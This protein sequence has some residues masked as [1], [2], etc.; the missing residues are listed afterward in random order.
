MLLCDGP[1]TR[2]PHPSHVMI[3]CC[4]LSVGVGSCSQGTAPNSNNVRQPLANRAYHNIT[5]KKTVVQ[6]V[7][8]PLKPWQLQLTGPCPCG[9]ARTVVES[10]AASVAA[11]VQ[12]LAHPA[13]EPQEPRTSLSGHGGHR[14][15]RA[16]EIR[17]DSLCGGKSCSQFSLCLSFLLGWGPGGDYSG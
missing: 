9:A 17:K 13:R 14:A 2:L 8:A 6:G 3:A 5:V 15:N 10:S 4:L 12:R 1:F 16:G 11:Y 7:C